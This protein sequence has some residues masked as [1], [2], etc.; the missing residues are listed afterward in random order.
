MIKKGY[1]D[2]QFRSEAKIGLSD[3]VRVAYEST[4]ADVVIVGDGF[5]GDAE[6]FE[7]M[8]TPEAVQTLAESGVTN[9]FLEAPKVY[10]SHADDLASGRINSDEFVRNMISDRYETLFR[11]AQEKLADIADIIKNMGRAGIMVHFS[12]PG[13]GIPEVVQFLE[14]KEN[15]IEQGLTGSALITVLSDQYRD[16]LLARTDDRELAEFVNKTLPEGEKGVVLY[17][18]NHGSRYGDFE[19]HLS[20]GVRSVKLDVYASRDSY[21]EM[22]VGSTIEND[23][24]SLSFGED[25]ADGVYIMNDADGDGGRFYAT[26]ATSP[27]LSAAIEEKAEWVRSGGEAD[28]PP[29][30]SEQNYVSALNCPITFSGF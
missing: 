21:Q 11:D 25:A 29:V 23:F 30:V 27:E 12:D 16:S 6:L 5:H 17:G 13:N 28:F 20:D 24:T 18:A 7:Y 26:R 1:S 14:E 8:A 3:V 22:Q 10:Q 2:P 19:E 4:D 15:Y 9:M